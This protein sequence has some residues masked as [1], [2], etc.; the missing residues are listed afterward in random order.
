MKNFIKQH[1]VLF[2]II[3]IAAFFRYWQIG[4]LP[5]G[6]FPDEA[7]YGMDGRSVT[8]GD[9]QPFYER[10]NGREGLFMYFLAIAI[11][12]FGYHPWANH[13]V[14]ATFGV[15]TVILTYLLTKKLFD[16][17]TAYVASFLMAVSS[18]AVDMT[19]TAF[20]ANTLPFFGA[21]VIL[22][23]VKMF[24]DPDTKSRLRS[25][26]LAGL[27][28]GLGF[29]TYISYRM[30]PPLLIMFFVILVFA[31]RAD[32]KYLWTT[33][34]KQFLAFVAMLF[35]SFAWLGYYWFISHPDSFIGRAGQVSVFSPDLNHGDLKGTIIDVL[36]KTA[37]SFFTSGDLNYRHN[38]SGYPFLAPLVSPFFLLALIAFTWQIFVLLKQAW[39]RDVKQETVFKALLASWFWLMTVPE[40]TTAE[41]IP[42]GLRLIGTI[43]VIF[44]ISAAGIMWLWK[45]ISENFYL[46]RFRPVYASIFL[47]T[48]FVYGFYLYFYVAA[49][50]PDYYYSFRSDLTVVS[51]YINQRNN[52]DG[53]YL[54]LDAF[55][56]QTVDYLTTPTNEPY[57]LL[58]PENSYLQELKPGDQI[59]FTQSTLPDGEK[60][61]R[62]HPDIKLVKFEKN[63]F[64]QLIMVVY[65]K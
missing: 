41:G 10:G 7:A 60:Y 34:R 12:F 27:F 46:Q 32:L 48:L 31:H 40:I 22:F 45:K 49:N 2:A 42:H 21:L 26:L 25:S 61:L 28:A 56:V 30:M 5:D 8:R 3:L 9:I 15:G 39:K 55:S 23:V 54:S 1:W 44:I 59:I 38:V 47:A 36:K 33:Y 14:T 57:Q 19:R 6:L 50:D 35:I 43:P 62:T 63:K 51:D 18:Y 53:T 20:R 29:Y 65:E 11:S 37:L 17:K 58:V 52:K 16:Q 64:N 4:H 24:T 13:L